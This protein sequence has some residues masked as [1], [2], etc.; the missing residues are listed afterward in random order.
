MNTC[1]SI[2]NQGKRTFNSSVGAEDEPQQ[3]LEMTYVTMAPCRQAE[4]KVHPITIKINT[5]TTWKDNHLTC[6]PQNDLTSIVKLQLSPCTAIDF[7][8]EKLTK[9][10]LRNDFNSYRT[11]WKNDFNSYP[12]YLKNE[13]NSYPSYLK[14]EFNSYPNYTSITWAGTVYAL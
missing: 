6:K 3:V 1:A 5:H 11:D 9:N 4:F 7:I 13:F 8:N 2:F 10:Y 12:S 14:N